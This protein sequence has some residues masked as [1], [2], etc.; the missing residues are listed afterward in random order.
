[1]KKRKK[2][3][4]NI[5]PYLWSNIAKVIGFLL[6]IF[7]ILVFGADAKIFF[8][9]FFFEIFA[10][11]VFGILRVWFFS[12]SAGHAV[13]CAAAFFPGLMI[14][15]GV[16]QALFFSGEDA[17]LLKYGLPALAF[18]AVNQ[19]K[20]FRNRTLK[21]LEFFKFA[22][23]NYMREG[24]PAGKIYTENFVVMGAVFKGYFFFVY[25]LVLAGIAFV[26]GSFFMGLFESAEE[27][28]LLMAILAATLLADYIED[29]LGID[30]WAEENYDDRVAQL[31][32]VADMQHE[33]FGKPRVIPRQ[34]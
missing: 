18:V 23:A 25:K 33:Q 3:L 26:I 24:E 2:S 4:G 15:A 10:Y 29:D 5:L 28:L 9:V 16:T 1:M 20:V 31:I 11:M 8:A 19:F 34:S 30:E 12:R 21:Q 14:T 17:A 6:P 22:N 13:A 27:G 32:R 7:F